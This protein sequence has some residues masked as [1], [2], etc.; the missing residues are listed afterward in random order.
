MHR[1]SHCGQLSVDDLG[2]SVTL[3][4][5]VQRR[6]DLG[7]LTFID[8]RD[9]TGVAQLLV[10][11]SDP[12]LADAH[13]LNREDVLAARGTVARRAEEN[14]NPDMETGEIEIQVDRIEVLNRSQTPPFL[15]EGDGDDALEETRLRFRYVD[16]R[17]RKMQ[18]NLR[19]RHAVFQAMRGELA[20]RGFLEVETPVLTKSTPEGAR[21][22][23]VPSRFNKGAFY[24]LPQSPQLFKQLLMVA[25]VDRYFQLVKCFRDEDMRAD[26]QLEFTQL[27]LEIAFP[28][29]IHEVLDT[30]ESVMDRVAR[31]IMSIELP[32]PF[33]KIPHAEAI[34][35]FGSDKPDI[36]SGMEIADIAEIVRGAGF[37][38]FDGA[39]EKGH[40]VAA[41][42]AP[43]CAHYS[44]KQ[45]QDLEAIAVEAG[46]AGLLWMRLTEEIES[47]LAKHLDE[48]TL[49]R[50][51]ERAGAKTGD[52]VLLAAGD[53]IHRPLGEVRR[54]L[55]RQEGL[56]PEGLRFCW[57][58]DFPLFE[59][60]ED[61]KIASSHHPFSAPRREHLDRL[62]SRPLEVVSEAYDLVLNGA[63][64]GSGSRRI[65]QREVQE[66]VFSALG[67]GADEADRRFGFFLRALEYGA[68]PHAGFA[69]GVDRLIMILAGESSLRDVIAFPKTT[70]GICP[71][72][73]APMPIDARQLGDLGLAL[74]EG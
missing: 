9:H 13:T 62:E 68:P 73:E 56:E 17:R 32:R 44:R 52:L 5:W 24:A 4:G 12:Q 1:D 69:M 21:D 49:R 55:I 74:K 15:V 25:G 38:L 40:A 51:A 27:D 58:T 11:G 37:R 19:L 46:A 26:R 22:F 61:G 63:E 65:H 60:D 71:L 35:R 42:A 33:P 23:L 47:P 57:V 54:A 31:E 39:I 59:L 41:I 6:R 14:V 66:R 20:E 30:L 18:H 36:G 7:A 48:E 29:G 50:V 28:R 67:I 45:I 53:A 64:L 2:R 16:L 72:T 70:T 34:A 3:A 8:L 43:G 10:D